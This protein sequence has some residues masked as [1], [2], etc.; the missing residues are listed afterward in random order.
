MQVLIPK[1]YG[2]ARDF[3]ISNRLP[4]KAK[5]AGLR[6]ILCAPLALLYPCPHPQE[7]E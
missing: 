3:C 6:T 7:K 1:V 4:G 5:A 2:G